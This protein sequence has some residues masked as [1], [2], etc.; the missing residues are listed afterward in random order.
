MSNRNQPSQDPAD[1]RY[2]H[3]NLREALLD[4]VGETIAEKGVAGVSLRE[5]ARRAGVSHGAPAHHFGDKLGLLTAY[6]T[7]GFQLFGERM[8]AAAESAA[9]PG[10]RLNAIGVEYLRFALEEP[11][12]FEVMF[13]S[14]M[15][16]SDDDTFQATSKG[17]FGILADVAAEASQDDCDDNDPLVLALKS[18]A[19]VHG[20]ASLWA[21]GAISHFWPGDDLAE[22]AGLIFEDE[23]GGGSD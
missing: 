4:A 9:E 2:H 1:G 22:L 5:A 10:Q 19:L 6:S 14:D 7:R 8:R 16:A 3:G 17:A 11:A 13:R 23:F 12:Y 18:W 20:L 21:D 15:H